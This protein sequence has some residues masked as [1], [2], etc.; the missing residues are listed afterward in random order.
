MILEAI[1]KILELARP[2]KLETK[3]GREFFVDKATAVPPAR[4]NPIELH[5]LGGLTDM[6]RNEELTD[7]DA[8]IESHLSVSLQSSRDPLWEQRLVFARATTGECR[9]GYGQNMSIERFIIQLQCHFVDSP[10]KKRIIDHLANITS[11]E[12]LTC[13][14]DGITQKVT[15]KTGVDNRIA[16]VKTEPIVQLEPYRTFREL[17]QPT[18][19]FLLRMTPGNDKLPPSVALHEAGGD[20]W[21]HTAINSIYKYLR[22]RLPEANAVIR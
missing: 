3:N 14:D 15:R 5:T 4:P 22:Q 20:L 2:E 18:D 21:K 16:A 13:E 12:V 6:I 10:V 17:D 8:Y 7:C 19:S 11:S 9:F 1:E